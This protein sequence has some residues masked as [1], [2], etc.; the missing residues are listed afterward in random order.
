[1]SVQ[2]VIDDKGKKT[3]VVIPL[4][5]YEELLERV[6]DAEALSMLK[7][8]KK[9]SLDIRSFDEFINEQS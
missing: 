9:K 6:E 3:G 7:E 4:E 2:Y 8:M 5:E 1:M